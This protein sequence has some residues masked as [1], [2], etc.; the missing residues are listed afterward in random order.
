[1]NTKRNHFR[2]LTDQVSVP[3]EAVAEAVGRSYGT[4]LA[5]R[6]GTRVAPPEVFVALADFID[7]HHARL[8]AVARLA[9]RYATERTP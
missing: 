1:M 7:K 8:P 5:Y 9:R 3:L 2:E 4:V 6:A